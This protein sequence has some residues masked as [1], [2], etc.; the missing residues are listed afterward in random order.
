MDWELLVCIFII[1]ALILI[2]LLG[3]NI[4]SFDNCSLK[5]F[6]IEMI[7]SPLIVGGYLDEEKVFSRLFFMGGILLI[8][9][10]NIIIA[11]F[12]CKIV[13]VTLHILYW[14][15]IASIF[16]ISATQP[17]SLTKR[18]C[19]DLGAL[20]YGIYAITWLISRRK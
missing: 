1:N 6:F 17:C 9:G 7:G 3:N 11:L 8:Y 4:L 2:P 14:V 18:I 12:P 20:C 16:A 10:S 13:T 19:I 15:A 5:I